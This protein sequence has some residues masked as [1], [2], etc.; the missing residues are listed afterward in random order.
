MAAQLSQAEQEEVEDKEAV[1][2][3]V[4]EVQQGEEE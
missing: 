2:W 3:G 1:P 4:A